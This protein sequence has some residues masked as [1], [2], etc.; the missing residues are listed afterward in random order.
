MKKT[1]KKRQKDGQKEKSGTKAYFYA[2]IVE[3]LYTSVSVSDEGETSTQ[4]GMAA[5]KKFKLLKN[6]IS[7]HNTIWQ[8]MGFDQG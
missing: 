1:N 4:R 7:N 8:I 2:K 3:N 6:A 5:K